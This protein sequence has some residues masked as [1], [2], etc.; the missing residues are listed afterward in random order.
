MKK[1]VIFACAFAF[2]ACSNENDKYEYNRHI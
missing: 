2:A 1:T